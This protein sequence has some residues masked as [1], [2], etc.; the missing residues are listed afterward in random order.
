MKKKRNKK[1]LINYFLKRNKNILEK[2]KNIYVYNI[3]CVII[4]LLHRKFEYP[5]IFST[6]FRHIFFFDYFML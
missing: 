4:F 6:K 5:N 3:F 1:I 2:L